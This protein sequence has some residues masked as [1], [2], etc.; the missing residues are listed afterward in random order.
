MYPK[1]AAAGEG[2]GV[3][4]RAGVPG[5]PAHDGG[6]AGRAGRGKHFNIMNV[7]LPE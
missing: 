6:P 4:V 7:K 2:V 1:A 5:A 3:A